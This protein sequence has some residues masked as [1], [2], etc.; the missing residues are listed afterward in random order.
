M[1]VPNCCRL[2]T[3]ITMHNPEVK[4]AQALAGD[5]IKKKKTPRCS[6]LQLSFEHRYSS[7]GVAF[8]VR[9]RR[10][11]GHSLPYSGRS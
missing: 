3:M 11:R 1:E 9:E 8:H 10:E 2:D 4:P 6:S 5:A 7:V